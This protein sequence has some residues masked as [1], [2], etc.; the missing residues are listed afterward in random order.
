MA[1]EYLV[2][3]AD[4]TAVADAIRAKGGTSDALTF[5]GGFVEAVGAIQAGSGETSSLEDA[6]IQRQ[7]TTYENNRVTTFA[8][9]ALQDNKLLESVSFQEVTS[10][11]MDAFSGCSALKSVSLPKF[12]GG[13]SGGRIFQGCN[14][15]TDDSFYMPMYTTIMDGEFMNCTGLT[16]VPY[17]N[18]ITYIKDNSFMNCTGFVSISL[19]NVNYCG[20]SAF[21]GCINLSWCE[22]G[23]PGYYHQIR[24]TLFDG[25]TSLETFILRAE[26]LIPMQST[27]AFQNTP[28]ASGTGYIYVPSALVDSYKTETN[29]TT[30][31]NQIR[32]IEDYTEITGG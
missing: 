16:N 19:P 13:K 14:K 9:Y 12:A 1:N 4:L 2:N 17:A 5:P 29:W 28:I 30:Y 26:K 8:R 22:F 15:L 32:A 10:L 20:Y 6:L 31:A 27:N 18:Q 11:P 21:K 23:S 3:S 7:L 25:C 24:N